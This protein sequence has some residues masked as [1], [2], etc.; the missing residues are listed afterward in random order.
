MENTRYKILGHTYGT[1]FV[2]RCVILLYGTCAGSVKISVF[3]IF[4][5]VW[6]CK[7]LCL[8]CTGLVCIMQGTVRC[9]GR[10]SNPPAFAAFQGDS[11]PIKSFSRNLMPFYWEYYLVKV[12]RNGLVVHWCRLGPASVCSLICLLFVSRERGLSC[13]FRSSK[14]E[15]RQGFIPFWL[16]GRWMDTAYG[17]PWHDIVAVQWPIDTLILDCKITGQR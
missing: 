14:P 6:F 15:C 11:F 9:V 17:Y 13:G 16:K 4:V 1:L 7:L 5:S 12:L 10:S 3:A 8:I 2:Q